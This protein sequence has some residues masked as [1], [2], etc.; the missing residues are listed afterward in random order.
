MH[1][2][3]PKLVNIPDL[4]K[5]IAR[6]DESPL[7]SFLFVGDPMSDVLLRWCRAVCHLYGLEVNNFTTC[8]A[9]GRAF[10]YLIHHYLPLVLPLSVIQQHTTRVRESMVGPV[11][12]T[13]GE[14]GVMSFSPTNTAAKNEK[15]AVH[16]ERKNYKAILQATREIG[17]PYLV[18]Y[19]DMSDTI[20]EEKVVL[21]FVAYLSERLLQL[22]KISFA[23]VCI[24]RALRH[25]LRLCQQVEQ[26]RAA[27]VL[28]QFIRGH[29]ARRE[30]A[31]RKAGLVLQSVVRG[32]FARQQVSQLRACVTLQ[33]SIRG[34]FSR[35]KTAELKASVVIQGN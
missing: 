33:K 30:A 12:G 7:N 29:L 10:C 2:E 27:A 16:N 17:V 14:N 3:L 31:H 1:A 13:E 34:H 21:V 9:D 5:E 32:H 4:E 15:Q 19:Q 35:Q 11:S 24:Q 8:F 28:Q 25:H 26:A 22:H 20:P 23:A 18:R 6:I